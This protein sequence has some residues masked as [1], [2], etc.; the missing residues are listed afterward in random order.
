MN[1]YKYDPVFG[2]QSLFD[3][4]IFGAIAVISNDSI[5]VYFND[6]DKFLIEVM[7]C[8]DLPL[9][10]LPAFALRRII[11]APKRW[12]QADRLAGVLPEVGSEC[13]YCD[14]KRKGIVK[15]VD[16]DEACIQTEQGLYISYLYDVEPIET[17]EEKAQ[18]LRG[19]WCA[20][21]RK[22]YPAHGH[23]TVE[24]AIY[25]AL[26]SGELQVPKAGE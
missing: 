17:P 16:G 13:Q 1:D 21:V 18:R 8:N 5:K 10:E 7:K 3:G 4:A 22:N 19:E 26:L 15:A 24:A 14:G 12:T 23:V 11:P 2:D 25:D 20:N 6:Y 9:P